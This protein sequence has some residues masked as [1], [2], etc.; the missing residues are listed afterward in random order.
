MFLHDVNQLMTDINPK[1]YPLTAN[2]LLV[3]DNPRNLMA[4]KAILD[5]LGQNLILANSGI[6]ALKYLLKEDV[7]IILMDVMMPD[8][9]G[10]ETAQ[11]IRKHP[12]LREVPIIFLTAYGKDDLQIFQGYSVGAVDYLV[13][14]FNSTILKAKVNV[15]I[16][17]FLKTAQI[18]QQK[19]QLRQINEELEKKTAKKLREQ[20]EL[21]SLT[22][23]T[24]IIRD[25]KDRIQVWNRGA[26]LLYGW[27]EEDVLGKVSHDLLKTN[28]PKPLDEIKTELLRQ[29]FWEGELIHTTRKGQ[30]IVVESRWSLQRDEDGNILGFL[31]I[32]ND[33]T[34]RKKADIDIRDALIRER[35]INE[36]KSNFVS[37]TTHE[38]RTP[39][40]SIVM[41]CEILDKY[42]YKL[43]DNK[44]KE[45][46]SRIQRST[47][48]M[49]LLID[50]VLTLSQADSEKLQLNLSEVNLEKFCSELI[51]EFQ[52]HIDDK[53][54]HSIELTSHNHSIFDIKKSQTINLDEKLL[55]HILSNLITNAIK[56]SPGEDS[57]ELLM[58]YYIDYVTIR[59]RDHGIGI[60]FK[61]QSQLFEA[62]HRATNARK[63]PGTGLGLSIVKRYVELHSGEI[64]FSSEVDLGSTFTVKLPRNLNQV[65]SR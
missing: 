41:S 56:Y 2:I 25:R 61:D 23:N 39:L 1:K 9:D 16:D 53:K 28:F 46:L 32:N 64:T 60:P 57:V 63:M 40:T 30:C 29:E 24:I 36:L 49:K 15:F 55:R 38:F 43:S 27:S 3:D 48:R 54:S 18:K 45:H 22:Y 20:A 8:I 19:A 50:D 6:E 5:E 35:K 21:L 52:L 4:L 33:I 14:P 44:K 47:E 11:L 59:V 42:S 58:D 31:E 26:R 17:I 13:K 10:F 7:A 62:F 65:E 37:M 51:E 34:E 12:R